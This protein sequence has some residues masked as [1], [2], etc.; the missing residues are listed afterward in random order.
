VTAAGRLRLGVVLTYLAVA[1]MALAASSN[2]WPTPKAGEVGA[3]PSVQITDGA[4]RTACGELVDGPAGRIRLTTAA[5]RVELA[6]SGLADIS[7]V[8]GC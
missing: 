6:T 5:G 2:W 7:P 8:D 4:G 1:V 3:G